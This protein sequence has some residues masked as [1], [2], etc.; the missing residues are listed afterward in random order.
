MSVKSA[1]I[2]VYGLVQGVGYRYAVMRIAKQHSVV[3][4]VRNL[5]DSRV[6]IHAEGEEAALKKFIDAIKIS[7]SMIGVMKVEVEWSDKPTNNFSSFEVM[8]SGFA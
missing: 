4:V 5:P 3:G 8:R 6:E 1:K 7:D 2:L